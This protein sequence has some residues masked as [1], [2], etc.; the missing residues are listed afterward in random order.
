[1]LPF[2][3]EVNNFFPFHET[4]V[5]P[6]SQVVFFNRAERLCSPSNHKSTTFLHLGEF[7]RDSMCRSRD[8]R[9]AL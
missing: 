6:S 9:N 7:R 2:A 1:M 5:S 3:F 4:F 8:A